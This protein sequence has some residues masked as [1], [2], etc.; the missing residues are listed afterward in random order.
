VQKNFISGIDHS[1]RP[2]CTNDAATSSCAIP[3]VHRVVPTDPNSQYLQWSTG[4]GFL[5][6]YGPEAGQGDYQ[7]TPA[8]GT[9]LMYTQDT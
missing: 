8:G 2:G 3:I 9:P 4:D 7:G 1:Q 5:D 6:W